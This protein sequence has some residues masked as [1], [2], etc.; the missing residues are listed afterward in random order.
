LPRSVNRG[1]AEKEVPQR[2]QS[3]SKTELK[4]MTPA[5]DAAG[6]SLGWTQTA[7][8]YYRNK[9]SQSPC[10][11]P[12]DY[13]DF[14]R[15]LEAEKDAARFLVLETKGKHLEGSADT[16]FKHKFF[17]LLEAAYTRGKEAGNI[18]LF[19]DAPDTI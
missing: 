8:S 1:V 10:K 19:A 6:I 2:L 16:E 12:G 14:L 15:H 11:M 4:K 17:T 3:K 18:E 9:Y 5:G 7:S 13:P